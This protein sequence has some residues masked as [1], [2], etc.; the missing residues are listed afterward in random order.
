MDKIKCVARWGLLLWKRLYK[1]AS[2]VLLLLL[3]PLLG[4][5]MGCL[6][7]AVAFIF[8]LKNSPQRRAFELLNITGC[9]KGI[10][11]TG[12]KYPLNGGEITCEYQYGVSNEVLPG[13]TAQVSVACGKLLLI[14]VW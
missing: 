14:K 7:M 13:E 3:I 2:F 11:I 9:A 6:C 10:T 4:L 5:G 12:A 1:K 8:N